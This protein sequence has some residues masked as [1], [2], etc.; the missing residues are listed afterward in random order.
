[1]TLSRRSLIGSLITLVAAPAIV[2]VASIMPVK[3]MIEPFC[4]LN[5]VP[6]YLD[7]LQVPPLYF[8]DRLFWVTKDEPQTIQ[9]SG[10]PL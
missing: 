10:L 2:R 6:I 1:M 8:Q 7:D 9:W 3:Q 5:G 4:M